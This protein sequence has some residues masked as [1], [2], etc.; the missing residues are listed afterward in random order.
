MLLCCAIKLSYPLAK[1]Y[2]KVSQNLPN[3]DDKEFLK[4]LIEVFEEGGEKAVKG[5]IKSMID[6][7]RRV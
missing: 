4:E 2:E 5:H 1:I 3:E 6:S 7:L